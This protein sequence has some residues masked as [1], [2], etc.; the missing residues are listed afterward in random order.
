M[1]KLVKVVKSQSDLS[2]EVLGDQQKDAQA[3]WLG[4][5]KLNLLS[6]NTGHRRFCFNPATGR[7]W[8]NIDA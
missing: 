2:T 7:S 3:F 5:A 6:V 1:F 8:S 4:V